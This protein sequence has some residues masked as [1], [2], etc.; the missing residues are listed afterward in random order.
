MTIRV[1]VADDQPLMR[2]A[3]EM[4]LSSEDDIEVVGEAADGREVIDQ[5]R[6]LHPDVIL[7]DI[8]MPKLD[9]V[10]AT[11]ILAAEDD[12][13]RILILTTFDIDEYVLE[14]LRAG[15]SG[16]LLKD[17]RAEELARAIRVV[18]DG[19]TLLAPSVT[20]RLLETFGEF[21]GRGPEQSRELDVLT[22]TERTV[23]TLIGRG[24]SNSEIAA[25]LSIADTTVR[26]HVR[27]IFEKLG[28]RDRVQAVVLAYR[29]G[30]VTPTAS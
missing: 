7:M 21:R 25:E 8:R 2:T 18:A 17:V 19:D 13:L 26:T 12:A 1:L 29:T 6:L 30:L 10:E 9:G 14:A 24:R 3:F 27:H 20:R 5:A 23:L 16:F 22:P 15:A 11:R 28:L 4:T